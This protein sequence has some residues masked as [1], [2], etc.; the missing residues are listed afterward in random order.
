[1]SKGLGWVERKILK[2]LSKGYAYYLLGL[3][4]NVF[5]TENPTDSQYK[6]VARAVHRLEHEKNMI[7]SGID[8]PSERHQFHQFY[9]YRK[10]CFYF[11]D[12]KF[13]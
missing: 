6:S 11:L 5:N 3:T 2:I 4:Y 1:M 10:K 7:K 8:K 12:Y 13:F 9:N